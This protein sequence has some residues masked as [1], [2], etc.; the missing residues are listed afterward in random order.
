MSPTSSKMLSQFFRNIRSIFDPQP[1]KKKQ[2]HSFRTVNR[3]FGKWATSAVED[4]PPPYNDLPESKTH[5]RDEHHSPPP[6]FENPRLQI[7]PH[8]T[9]SFEELQKVTSPSI[10]PQN[11]GTKDALTVH[12]HEHR[13]Q[14]DPITKDSRLFCTSSPGLLRGSG[15]FSYESSKDPS[16]TPCVILLFHWDLGALDGIRAQVETAAELQQFLGA[17]A[18]RLCPHK[19]ISDS[20]IINAVFGF[21]KRPSEAEVSTCCD[22]CDTEIKILMKMEDCDEMCRVTIRRCLGTAEKADDPKWL[23]QCGV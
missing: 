17:D 21:V 2:P 20:D 12:C 7:C 9:I 1:T 10:V 23:S 3:V 4:P 14:F 11:G 6:P 18:I 16:H 5:F 19:M 15:T 13:R 8:E 22:F